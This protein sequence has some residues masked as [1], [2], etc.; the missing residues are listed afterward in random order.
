MRKKT[1]STEMLALLQ[2]PVLPFGAP[3]VSSVRSNLPVFMSSA[4]SNSQVLLRGLKKHAKPQVFRTKMGFAS[5]RNDL[6]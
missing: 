1:K 5:T 2:S 4:R 6:L 3:Q